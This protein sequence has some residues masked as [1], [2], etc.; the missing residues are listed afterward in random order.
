VVKDIAMQGEATLYKAAI[1]GEEK[2]A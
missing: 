2:P 1:P